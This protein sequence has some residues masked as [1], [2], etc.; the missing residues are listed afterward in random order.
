VLVSESFRVFVPGSR[1]PQSAY[2]SLQRHAQRTAAIV[3]LFPVEHEVRDVAVVAALLHDIGRLF[4]ASTMPDEFCA[5]LARARERGRKLYVADLLTHELDEHD[6][7]AKGDRIAEEDRAC[8]E[9]L[10]LMLSFP[11]LREL[12]LRCA[13]VRDV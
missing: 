3:S 2:A 4:L 12:A 6:N 9:T 13:T 1:V 8:L 5:T 10:G 7:D 11:E